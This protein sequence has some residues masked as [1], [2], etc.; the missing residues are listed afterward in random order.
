[1]CWL[2]FIGV[3]KTRQSP[4]ATPLASFNLLSAVETNYQM[5]KHSAAA[6][7][8]SV[9][10]TPHEQFEQP[11]SGRWHNLCLWLSRNA[12][13]QN[14]CALQLRRKSRNRMNK[15]QFATTA[16]ALAGSS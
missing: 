10:P 2:P 16:L 14:D 9:R 7:E 12:L 6:I 8:M 15:I 1:M 11:A 13:A 5:N 3:D 4:R